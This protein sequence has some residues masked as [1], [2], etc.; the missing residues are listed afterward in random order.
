M[1]TLRPLTEHVCPALVHGLNSGS[2][3]SAA[4]SPPRW[5]GVFSQLVLRLLPSPATSRLPL[6]HD[7][8]LPPK[9]GSLQT[10]F[11][12]PQFFDLTFCGD[13]ENS[14]PPAQT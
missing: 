10:N 1:F 2:Q 11:I 3:G 12:L 6:T 14:R 7:T 5:P 9:S 4:Q 8:L 13:R